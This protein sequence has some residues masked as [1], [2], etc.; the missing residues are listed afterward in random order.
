MPLALAAGCATSPAAP[1]AVAPPG[2]TVSTAA[3]S[4]AAAAATSSA[5]A[6][7]KPG[8]TTA[9]KPGTAVAVK[10]GSTAAPAATAPAGAKPAP[11]TTAAPPLDS[12]LITPGDMG[13]D[14]N[15]EP[16]QA[17]ADDQNA[18]HQ[19]CKGPFKT[20]AQRLGRAQ[21]GVH[22]DGTQHRVEEEV[23]RYKPGGAKAALAEFREHF[24]SCTTWGSPPDFTAT[25]DGPADAPRIGE[26][27]VSVRV[28]YTAG[29]YVIHSV[30]TVAIQG[31]YLI[32]VNTVA[33]SADKALAV[34]RQANPVAAV[35]ARFDF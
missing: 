1:G 6:A 32:L 22:Q 20:D 4:G 34:A 13:D 31:D 10:P 2:G 33:P 3:A 24:S 29:A 7:A 19:Y 28:R 11:G 9:A 17:N 14:W 26:D 5:P 23:T 15:L 21:R 25:F 16:K 27:S 35:R 8:T 30:S 12:L 18:P